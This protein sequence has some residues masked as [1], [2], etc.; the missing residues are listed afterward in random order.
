MCWCVYGRY[1][2]G[3]GAKHHPTRAGHMLRGE[4]IVWVYA[5]SIL[6]AVYTLEQDLVDAKSS[7]E[8]LIASKYMYVQ[9]VCDQR[10]CTLMIYY[11]V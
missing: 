9:V 4:A 10:M 8:S 2:A 3:G 5:L 11:I 7:V 6:D 1:G